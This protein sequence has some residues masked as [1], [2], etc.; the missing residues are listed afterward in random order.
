M[1]AL[2]VKL[3]TSIR[4]FSRSNALFVGE[5]HKLSVFHRNII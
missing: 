5:V 1:V 3:V 4:L 2:K